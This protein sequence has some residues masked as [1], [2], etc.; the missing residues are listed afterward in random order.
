M[1]N[2][3]DNRIELTYELI[4]EAVQGNSKAEELIFDYY[5]PYIIKLSK[6][7]YIDDEGNVKYMIDEDIYMNLKLKLHSL[8]LGFKIA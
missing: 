7:P 3:R 6:V 8:I 4:C 5:E 1:N 2:N